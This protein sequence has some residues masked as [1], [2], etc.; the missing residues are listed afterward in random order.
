MNV[1]ATATA[2]QALVLMGKHHVDPTPLNYS[3][4]YTYVVG[5][6]PALKDEVDS[7]A[8]TG[9]PFT[10]ETNDYLF[11]KYLA[12]QN[13]KKVVE[14]ASEQVKVILSEIVRLID[15]I[16]SDTGDFGTDLEEF[17][18]SI[19]FQAK[20]EFLK[21]VVDIIINKTK[22]LG[23]RSKNVNKRLEDS[24]NEIRYLRQNLEKIKIE[25]HRDYLTG[26]GNRKA[27][28]DIII[29]MMNDAKELN[30]PLCL[31]MVDVD[32]FKKFNDKWGHQIGDEILKLVSDNIRDKLRG[33]DFVARYGGEEFAVLL[34]DTPLSGALIVAEKLRT[35]IMHKVLRRRDN[36][37]EIG[38]VTVSIG[39]SQYKA[40]DKTAAF[41]KRAD[42]ALYR[43]KL[44]GRNKVTQENFG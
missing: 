37:E 9:Q 18:K 40:G 7:M 23:E 24:N 13:D 17:G 20:N 27:F 29:S 28:D 33:A 6:I 15:A 1:D 19:A 30:Q 12:D 10:Q 43:S 26:V 44:G 11:R 25:S 5:N 22:R 31:L 14:D 38:S 4:W 2:K 3:V 32:H 16:S 21:P 36:G 39:V 35:T 41:I 42:E 8:Q 34:P